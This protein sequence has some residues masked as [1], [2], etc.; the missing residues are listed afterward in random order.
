MAIL[1]RP[2]VVGN[3]SDVHDSQLNPLGIRAYD[4]FGGEY[5]YLKGVASVVQG[6][7][8]AI[9]VAADGVVV[10]LDTDVAGSL[11]SRV[12]IAMAAIT[13]NKYG[14]F[15]VVSPQ[16]GVDGLSAASATDTK[17]VVATSTVFVVDDAEAGAEVT[18]FGALYIGAE[19]GGH[20]NFSISNPY[21][22]ALTLD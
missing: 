16:T 7:W 13:A 10:G 15:C 8:V 20:A 3:T 14:W 18:V 5:L 9:D 21:M 2:A 4:A 11:K 6:A 17:A 19:S 12:A 22:H 1:V